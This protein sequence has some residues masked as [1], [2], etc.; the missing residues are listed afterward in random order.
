MSR[1]PFELVLLNINVST[2]VEHGSV[3]RHEMCAQHTLSIPHDR[4]QQVGCRGGGGFD[5][6]EYAAFHSVQDP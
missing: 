6:A 4:Y 1:E 3:V 5:S 2:T